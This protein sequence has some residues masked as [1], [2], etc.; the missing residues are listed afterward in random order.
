MRNYK[1][2]LLVDNEEVQVNSYG[3]TETVAIS[4]VFLRYAQDGA[5]ELKV[6]DITEI[7]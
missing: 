3:Y 1:I 4:Q 2:T 5:R 7:N 6:L